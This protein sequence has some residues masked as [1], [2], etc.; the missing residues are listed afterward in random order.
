MFWQKKNKSPVTT[1][2]E[3]WIEHVKINLDFFSDRVLLTDDGTI[4]T[5]SA[6]LDGKFNSSAGMYKQTENGAIIYI[7]EGQLKYPISFNCNYFT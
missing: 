3:K 4:L 6:D 1:E 7:D 5:S 2:D